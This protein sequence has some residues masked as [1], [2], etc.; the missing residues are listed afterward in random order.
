VESKLIHSSEKTAVVERA[1]Q[2]INKKL[3]S[4]LLN[5][6]QK[7][8]RQ[9]EDRGR[10]MASHWSYRVPFAGVRYYSFE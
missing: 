3:V 1:P 10:P 4:Q 2:E 8:E 7:V 9:K 6:V 5:L